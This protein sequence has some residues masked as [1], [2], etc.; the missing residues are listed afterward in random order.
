MGPD[1]SAGGKWADCD[2]V[3]SHHPVPRSSGRFVWSG[4][5]CKLTRLSMSSMTFVLR[6]RLWQSIAIKWYLSRLA[7][8]CGTD[9]WEDMRIDEIVYV[10]NDFRAVVRPVC[11]VLTHGR[12]RELMR[13]S[14][15]SMTLVL[16]QAG[17][18]GTDAWEDMRIDE[19]VYVINEF[20]AE[21]AKCHYEKHEKRKKEVKGTLFSTSAPFYLSILDAHVK[22]NNGYLA[23]GK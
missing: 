14:M 15:L 5:I 3:Y 21:L 11:V 4:R 12:I 19:I 18:C 1:S 6:D 2:S 17:L 8:L 13:L 7:G 22:A 16:R 23:N 20:R 9:A 10:I